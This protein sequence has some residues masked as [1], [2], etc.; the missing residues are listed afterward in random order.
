MNE[1]STVRP[2]DRVLA[3]LLRNPKK[4][5]EIS[6]RASHIWFA[7]PILSVA[8]DV[9]VDYAC[10]SGVSPTKE[11]LIDLMGR[12]DPENKKSHPEALA[13]VYA[14]PPSKDEDQHVSYYC[15]QLEREWKGRVAKSVMLAA[16]DML[17]KGNVDGAVES[18][19]K[20]IAI[21][22]TNFTKSS[23]A[24]DFNAFWD[25]YKRIEKD[26]S[27]RE[28]V[29]I[30]FPTID[31]ATR[32]HFNKEL[33]VTVGGSGVGKSLLM[34]Q[35]AVNVAGTQFKDMLS[36]KLRSRRVLLV[37]I[38]NSKEAYL[39]RLY[40]NVCSVPYQGL[41]TASLSEDNQGKLMEGIAMLPNDYCLDVVHMTP[42]CCA[43]DILNIMRAADKAYDYL[44]VDQITNM[45]PNN[46]REFR[47]MDWRWYSQITLELRVLADIS[48]NHRGIPVLS[49]VHAAGGTTD[50][51]EL[52]TD[53]TALA[54]AIGY[55]VDALYY[56][57]RK[58]GE[59]ILG[60]SKLR[61]AHFDPVT[62]YPVWEYW[63]LQEAPP[64][65]QYGTTIDDGPDAPP[66][67][68]D[69]NLDFNVDELEKE[70]SE[71]N[72]LENEIASMGQTM[73]DDFEPELP[74]ATKLP[75]TTPPA[76]G[77][78]GSEDF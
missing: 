38:E 28:G 19:Q 68:I 29:K 46:P 50:K 9:A 23:L 7:S 4:A 74:P 48:Y 65:N 15:E 21:P 55:H 62:V 37:T 17:D 58:D 73:P 39:R 70:I 26:P 22:V 3:V 8:F 30:G 11:M 41:K 36:G 61:D 1:P 51:K 34:G 10:E 18:L 67:A 14:I 16:A 63:R 78:L 49:A 57:T 52:T 32:G 24:L 5:P 77:S 56:F 20:D 6:I 35:V 40:S 59:Y 12:R 31:E 72:D 69:K 54:K 71:L 47:V 45:A 76:S 2:E 60:K 64:E 43:R 53:D 44:I 13:R 42:P 33:I 66:Q 25:D 27:R 75:D